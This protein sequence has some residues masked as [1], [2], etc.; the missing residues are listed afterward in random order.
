[1]KE[2]VDKFSLN[3]FLSYLCPGVCML[4]SVV[5]WIRPDFSTALGETLGGKE[6]IAVAMVLIVGYAVGLLIAAWSS[7]GAHLFLSGGFRG[8]W[9][10]LNILVKLL[11][12]MP[13]DKAR[14]QAFKRSLVENKIRIAEGL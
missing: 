2:M 13:T 11:H 6:G 12:W 4:L 9:R 14:T 10:R 8:R 7:Q 1:M 3:E 5:L